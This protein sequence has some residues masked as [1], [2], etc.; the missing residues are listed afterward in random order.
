MLPKFGKFGISMTEVIKSSVL[1]AFD[2]KNHF[3]EGWSWFEFN[4]VGLALGVNLKFY[5]R[6]VKTKI[7]KVLRANY[8]VCRGYMRRTGR[9]DFFS[10]S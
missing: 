4:N 10:L 6:K 3:F 7:Q 8:Y 5:P 1:L 2:Q 9:V